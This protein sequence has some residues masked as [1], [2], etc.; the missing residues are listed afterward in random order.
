[1]I[2]QVI[3]GAT[4]AGVRKNVLAPQIIGK[5]AKGVKVVVVCAGSAMVD[6]MVRHLEVPGVTEWSNLTVLTLAR[7]KEMTRIDGNLRSDCLVVVD[8]LPPQQWA[9]VEKQMQEIPNEVWLY[10]SHVTTPDMSR[11][12]HPAPAPF[13]DV[14]KVQNIDVLVSVTGPTGSGKTLAVQFLGERL[15]AAGFEVT[16]K[17][18]GKHGES[19]NVKGYSG[20]FFAVPQPDQALRVGYSTTKVLGLPVTVHASSSKTN[21]AF[22][23]SMETIL[24]AELVTHQAFWQE[25]QTCYAWAAEFCQIISDELEWRNSVAR[26]ASCATRDVI[27]RARA[28]QQM[29]IAEGKYNLE[30]VW[31]MVKGAPQV[32]VLTKVLLDKLYKGD[33]SLV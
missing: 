16:H 2:I 21:A 26:I 28:T 1:M 31:G 25:K 9:L 10:L 17:H 30:S 7:W 19:I 24:D 12:P 20:N 6:Q 11:Y 8:E 3:S 18:T 4:G 5:L 33:G 27:E 13:S 32:D 22:V 14:S 29:L 23:R 15:A